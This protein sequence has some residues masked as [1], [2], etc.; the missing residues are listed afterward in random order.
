[1][2]SSCV[3]QVPNGLPTNSVHQNV[4]AATAAETGIVLLNVSQPMLAAT[5]VEVDEVQYIYLALNETL[6]SRRKIVKVSFLIHIL[7]H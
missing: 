1:M 6:G 7:H 3:F 4:I 5:L 2:I